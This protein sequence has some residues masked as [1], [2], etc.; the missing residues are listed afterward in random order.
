MIPGTQTRRHGNKNLSKQ[1]RA[2]D[3]GKSQAAWPVVL[4]SIA[5]LDAYVAKA[6]EDERARVQTSKQ[7]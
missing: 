7:S 4:P 5:D 2:K 3:P 6:M 1:F